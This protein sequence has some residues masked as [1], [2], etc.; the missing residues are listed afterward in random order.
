ME[1]A[2][3]NIGPGNQVPPVLKVK[4]LVKTFNR[5]EVVAL[6]DVSFSVNQGEIEAVL[7]PS[8]CGKTTL[9]RLIAG[10]EYPDKGDVL[11]NGQSVMGLPPHRRNIGLVFQ[12]LAVFPHK[13]I[14]Q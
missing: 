10:L 5:G 14:F 8:G 9:M 3:E 1:K 4:N 2:E 7:G 11:V 12:D 13:S 6:D